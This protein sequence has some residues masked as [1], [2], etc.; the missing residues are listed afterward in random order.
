MSTLPRGLYG[1]LDVAPGEP[2][3]AVIDRAR[4][5]VDHGVLAVQLRAKHHTVEA[6]GRIAARLVSVAPRLIVNDHVEIAREL[7]AWVHL[8]QSDG[9]DPAD[10]H[11]AG[12]PYGRSTHTLDQVADADHACY[13]GFGPVFATNTKATGYS[14]RGLLAL[15]AAVRTSRVPVVA[16]GGIHVGNID[17]V[18]ATGVHAWAP[19]SGFWDNRADEAALRR[20][21]SC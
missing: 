15:A 2:D 10:L 11:R 21:L 16:I 19:I 6:V 3:Q 9:P 17:A 18:R 7:G 13:V 20:L 14:P 12:L 1:M 4:F 5:L 8:G